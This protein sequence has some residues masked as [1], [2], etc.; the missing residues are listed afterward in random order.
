MTTQGHLVLEDG[1]AFPG[2]IF[3]AEQAV[4][5]EV[6]FNTGMVGYPEYLTDPSFAG[7]IVV[8]TYP[9]VGNY[10]VPGYA[11]DEN[12]LPMGFESE[13][14]QVCGF[15]VSTLASDTSHWTA[16]R[17]LHEWMRDSGIPGIQGV[18]TRA[19]AKRIR[20]KGVMLG[21]LVPDGEDIGFID[22]NLTNLAAGVSIREPKWYGKGN[23]GPRV[24]LVDTGTKANII[25]SLVQTGARVLRVPWDY[26]FFIEEFDALFLSNGPGDPKMADI[27]V[28]NVKRAVDDGNIPIFGICLGNQLLALAAGA[29][30]YKLKFGHRAQNQPCLEVGTP[31]CFITSQNHGYAVNGTTLP[32]GWREWFTNANDGSNEGIRHEWKPMRSVQFH[33]EATPGPVDTVGLFKRFLEMIR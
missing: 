22:P 1:S 17:S 32:E 12:D 20:E 16:Q 24:V 26:D 25:R 23:S 21:K 18:D 30:T 31:R 15:V 27:T 7:Q 8:A 13:R 5:G 28:R 10:G 11:R 4:A 19:L 9:L 14:I 29:D 2:T 3:G 6:V 33:P